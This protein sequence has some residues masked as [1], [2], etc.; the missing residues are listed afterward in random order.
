MPLSENALAE[1]WYTNEKAQESVAQTRRLSSAHK[2]VRRAC[3]PSSLTARCA[4]ARTRRCSA[5]TVAAAH[6]AKPILHQRNSNRRQSRDHRAQSFSPAAQSTDLATLAFDHLTA[7]R[8][9][10]LCAITFSSHTLSVAAASRCKRAHGRDK[11]SQLFRP[12]YDKAPPLSRDSPDLA[13]A[14]NGRQAVVRGA[15]AVSD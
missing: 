1:F 4:S 10:S 2:S 14:G 5:R 15:S 7:S 9:R 12:W 8:S 3:A 11:K 13:C 6:P